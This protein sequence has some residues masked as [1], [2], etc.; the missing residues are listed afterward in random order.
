[1]LPS[2]RELTRS[3]VLGCLVT[4][5]AGLLTTPR[6]AVGLVHGTHRHA[7]ISW[8][9]SMAPFERE[10]GFGTKKKLYQKWSYFP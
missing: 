7:S 2:L 8:K 10:G 9:G 6:P 1:M 4:R 5:P 3:N